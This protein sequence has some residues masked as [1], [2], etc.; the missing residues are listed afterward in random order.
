MDVLESNGC[1]TTKVLKSSS[2]SIGTL[3]IYLACTEYNSGENENGIIILAKH[4]N[5]EMV[6]TGD[7]GIK[8]EREYAALL[9][10]PDIEVIIAGH[11][12]SK[13]STG[14]RLLDACTP[15]AAIISVGANSYG[16]PAE[17]T[18]ERFAQR[19]IL[20]YRTD[21]MGEITFKDLETLEKRYGG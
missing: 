15:E 16:H 20:V 5:F 12:G 14:E 1:E 17:E 18:L 2:I 10:L 4:G 3:E 11:H 7:V 9:N 21:D 13:G 19:K 6:V 8:S